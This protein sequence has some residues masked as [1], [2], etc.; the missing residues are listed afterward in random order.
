MFGTV[1]RRLTGNR[2]TVLDGAAAR[3]REFKRLVGAF[4]HESGN[5]VNLT[6]NCLIGRPGWIE[7]IRWD[8]IIWEVC[9]GGCI[10]MTSAVDIQINNCAYWD[11]VPTANIY[12]FTKGAA[13]YP[14]RNIQVHG[15]RA[16]RHAS[17]AL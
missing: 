5:S 7:D 2:F 12:S 10:S 3:D 13:G 14:C 16:Q 11:T 4:I 1:A 8:T 9:T 15:G 17:A 6:A